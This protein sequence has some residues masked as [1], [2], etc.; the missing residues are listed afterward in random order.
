MNYAPA[1][2]CLELTRGL[3]RTVPDPE[4]ASTKEFKLRPSEGLKGPNAISI[5]PL[6]EPGSIVPSLQALTSS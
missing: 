3:A 6:S 5:Q 2:Q 4:K 1:Q